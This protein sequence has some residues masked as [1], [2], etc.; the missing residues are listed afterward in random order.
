[1]VF[2][3]AA[4]LFLFLPIAFFFVYP[5]PRRSQN[6]ALLLL[7][8]FFYLWGAGSHIWVIA[9]VSL[10]SWL[11]GW[12]IARTR[13]RKFGLLGLAAVIAVISAPL[14]FFKYAPVVGAVFR[15]GAFSGSLILP[16][17][18]SFFTFHAI[19]YVVDIY[20]GD[21]APAR[22]LSHYLLYLF[23]FPHQ[24]AGPI[25]RF[26][27]I[28]DEIAARTK[29]RA[30]D[31]IYGLSRFGW[32]LLKKT[33]VADQ[34]G[35]VADTLYAD[36]WMLNSTTAWIAVFAYAV[37]IYFDFSAY[38]DMALG[39]A[40]IFNFHF[41]ENFAGPYRSRSAT[42]FWQRWHMTLSRWFRDYVYI[43]F[44]GNRHGRAREYAGLLLTFA[45]TSLWH[46]AM[47]NYLIWGGMWSGLLLIE[48]ITGLRKVQ[49]FQVLRRAFMVVFI[50]FSWVPFRLSDLNQVWGIWELLLAG[51]FGPLSP[52][53]IFAL[54]P[55][56]ISALLV[57][58]LAFAS[59]QR[60][61]IRTFDH[62]VL[63]DNRE[64]RPVLTVVIGLVALILGVIFSLNSA[65]SPFLY[66]QF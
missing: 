66:Y 61:R 11:L 51:D 50:L 55:L 39:L 26:S 5:L 37:Q 25:V 45:L 59:P 41:P 8:I 14:V 15:D 38:S 6:Y 62:L 20:R 22:N 13:N 43:P 49:K 65:F 40:R 24:I 42:E 30:E 27:E 60:I 21:L 19:S 4:F 56:A 54:H 28:A 10:V 46:G 2:S 23:I 47:W 32:G 63:Q 52:V 1:M 17:G 57:G 31:V 48:R 9:S 12:L 53:A 3:S 18:I 33:Y 58:A 7:S 35:A 16:L 44:G 36:Q 29:A 34:A 64:I